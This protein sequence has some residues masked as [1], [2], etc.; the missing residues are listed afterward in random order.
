[1]LN[2]HRCFRYEPDQT[3]DK[4]HNKHQQR[5][6]DIKRNLRRD[7]PRVETVR[8]RLARRLKRSERASAARRLFDIGGEGAEDPVELQLG[9]VAGYEDDEVGEVG[10][11]PGCCVSD[12]VGWWSARFL[13]DEEFGRRGNIV[14]LTLRSLA[15]AGNRFCC[16]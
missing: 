11:D 2:L 1:M 14:E 12:W 8:N 3:D 15:R 9:P 13:T 4:R 5:S 10:F 7:P 6:I 16:R